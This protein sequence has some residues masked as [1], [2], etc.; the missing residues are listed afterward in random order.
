[1]SQRFENGYVA[2]VIVCVVCL[3]ALTIV[4]LTVP[5]SKGYQ[6]A[7]RD[8]Q[9]AYAELNSAE[10]YYEKCVAEPTVQE[11]LKCY[12]QAEDRDRE[13]QTTEQDLDA[14]REMANWAEGMLWATVIVG[15][16]TVLVTGLGVYWVKETLRVT[17]DAVRSADA[18]VNVQ[19]RFGRLQTQG[20]LSLDKVNFVFNTLGDK[21]TGVAVQIH[22]A[23]FGNTPIRIISRQDT[24]FITDDPAKVEAAWEY[25]PVEKRYTSISKGQSYFVPSNSTPWESAIAEE[26]LGN[27]FV[28]R[29]RMG[30]TD[31]FATSESDVRFINYFV[32][33]RPEP[34]FSSMTVKNLG[35]ATFST[36]KHNR[37]NDET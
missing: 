9:S 3:L 5:Y 11:A 6:T 15:C 30:Y 2:L 1:M 17:K 29:G 28:A 36:L 23:N 10:E 33:V 27:F 37:P 18:A 25:A 34:A 4:S 20:Y 12:Q 21:I 19:E 14:Q 8:H 35:S 24:C 32:Q 26:A 13:Q 22:V 16:I 7:D 31:I